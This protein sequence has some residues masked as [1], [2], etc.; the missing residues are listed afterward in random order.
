MWSEY[1]AYLAPRDVGSNVTG[2]SN[3]KRKTQLKA[4]ELKT[5]D[6]HSQ[7]Y[8]RIENQSAEGFHGAD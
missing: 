2:M 3:G 1:L 7:G 6:T 4:T 5:K 8:V